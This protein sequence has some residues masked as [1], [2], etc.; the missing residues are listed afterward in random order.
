[1]VLESYGFK[2]KTMSKTTIARIYS[3]VYEYLSKG[4]IPQY[5]L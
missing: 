4:D 2:I 5:L 1:M 3:E